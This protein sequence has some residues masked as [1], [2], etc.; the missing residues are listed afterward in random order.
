[1]RTNRDL[2][3]FVNELSKSYES[4]DRS[5]EDYLRALL[6][7]GRRRRA[8]A[9]ISLPQFVAMLEES[10][11]LEPS[12]FDPAW[13]IAPTSTS[14]DDGYSKWERTILSLIVDLHRMK[15]LGMFD[16]MERYFAWGARGPHATDEMAKLIK[17]WANL[18]PLCFL[19]RGV[20]GAFG[21]DGIP[22]IS[23]KNL[24]LPESERTMQDPIVE[25]ESLSWAEFEDFLITCKV[26]E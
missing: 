1:M 23:D 13:L 21:G 18:D 4:S 8:E 22:T 16:D 14:F 17:G 25:I 2:Y 20:A 15:A 3:Q 12:A 10:F 26:Y 7:L 19:E 6:I 9:S 5:L 11:V 24:F